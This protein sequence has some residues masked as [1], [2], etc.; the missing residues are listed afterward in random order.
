[1]APAGSCDVSCFSVCFHYNYI[2]PNISIDLCRPCAHET[3]SYDIVQRSVRCGHACYSDGNRMN[4][5]TALVIGTSS[6]WYLTMKSMR[7]IFRVLMTG[8][9]LI[10]MSFDITWRLSYSTYLKLILACV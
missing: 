9:C 3:T 4:I 7:I 5:S 6:I 2:D 10:M 8:A 1:M